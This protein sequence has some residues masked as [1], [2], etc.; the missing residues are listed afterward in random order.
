MGG[1]HN[2]K[3][4]EESQAQARAEALRLEN[5]RKK[6]VEISGHIA[7]SNAFK[8]YG[9]QVAPFI[10]VN[11]TKLFHPI[12]SIR[13][14]SKN[15]ELG[16]L[17]DGGAKVKRIEIP[18][19]VGKGNSMSDVRPVILGGH[20]NALPLP[21]VNSFTDRVFLLPN[22]QL[23]HEIPYDKVSRYAR[24]STCERPE[25]TDS[26][27]LRRWQSEDYNEIGFGNV[28]VVEI[29]GNSAQTTQN[30]EPV[31]CRLLK[32]AVQANVQIPEQCIVSP[33]FI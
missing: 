26:I 6:A 17:L 11:P 14:R 30:L 33:R 22:Q 24:L 1:F 16:G 23:V 2:R 20:V 32:L 12:R 3:V 7:A 13:I 15:H 18:V 29:T 31:Y 4:F 21:A 19:N 27:F 5:L 28:P 25:T 8:E 10:R 9:T